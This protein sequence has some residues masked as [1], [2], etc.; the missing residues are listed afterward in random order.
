MTTNSRLVEAIAQIVLAMSAEERQLFE[1]MIEPAACKNNNSQTS[2]AQENEAALSK[3]AQIAQIAQQMQ[4]FEQH[5]A[6]LTPLP[7][8]Q[9][10][11]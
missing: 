10:S 9:W 7:D 5:A 4:D 6:P 2:N 8:D 11:L 3:D 1:Q